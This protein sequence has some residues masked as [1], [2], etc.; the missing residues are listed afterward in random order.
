M[1]NQKREINNG[2]LIFNLHSAVILLDVS[3]CS[4]ASTNIKQILVD[5][6]TKTNKY[7]KIIENYML[8]K[9]FAQ[10]FS[11]INIFKC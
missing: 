9:T 7:S 3:R 5:L 11:H 6:H 4:K 8:Y 10:T 1:L 2:F